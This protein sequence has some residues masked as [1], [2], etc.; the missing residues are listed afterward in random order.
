MNNLAFRKTALAL[1]LASAPASA[2]AIL[3]KST[4]G[5][6]ETIAGP[7]VTVALTFNSRVDQSRSSLTL[8]SPDHATSRVQIGLDPRSPAKL[9]AKLSSLTTGSYKLRWQVLA[10]DGHVTRGE[11]TFHV[12]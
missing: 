4:P 8:E 7:N 9:I 10:V 11:I 2:H 6:N 3:L 12:K 5:A 1:A